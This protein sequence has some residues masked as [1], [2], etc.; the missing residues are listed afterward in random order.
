MFLNV[1]ENN[2]SRVSAS[3]LGCCS[4]TTS[5]PPVQPLALHLSHLTLH[6]TSRF[7]LQPHTLHYNLSHSITTSH[8]SLQPLAWCV[9]VWKPY[10]RTLPGQVL[11]RHTTNI[12][13]LN[14]E[15]NNVSRVSA[16]SLGCCSI[17]TSHP[18]VQP[19]T[20]HLSHLTLHLTSHFPL[21]PHTIH[22]NLSHSITTS[23]PSLQPLA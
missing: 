4:I 19:L 8:P 9:C 23:H 6:I 1:E 2:V 7:P 3:S 13:F 5:H 17:T 15:E 21:Q 11:G 18:P 22:C 16:P 14:V 10:L 20:L 12:M